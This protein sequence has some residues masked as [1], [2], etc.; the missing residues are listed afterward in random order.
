LSPGVTPGSLC[1]ST[2]SLPAHVLPAGLL[3]QYYQAK[4]GQLCAALAQPP[5]KGHPASDEDDAMEHDQ[6][7]PLTGDA[8]D[9]GSDRG[10]AAGQGGVSGQWQQQL[11]QEWGKA[12]RQVASCLQALGLGAA[13]EEAYTQVVTRCVTWAVDF[14]TLTACV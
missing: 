14:L 10:G 6:G 9:A 1:P 5:G 8:S 11:G 12:L 4:L 7:Q 13:S 2:S 3:Q